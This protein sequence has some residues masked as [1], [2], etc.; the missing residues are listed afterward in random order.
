MK[1]IHIYANNIK[2]WSDYVKNTDCF[3]NAYTNLENLKQSL[4]HYNIRDVLGF[5]LYPTIFTDEIFTFLNFI[6]NSYLSTKIPVILVCYL[7][8]KALTM[9]SNTYP[10]L[11]LYNLIPEDDT[12]SDLDINNI[13]TLLYAANDLIYD[14]KEYKDKHVHLYDKK[15]K[16]TNDAMFVLDLIER[17]TLYE[18][19]E[20]ESNK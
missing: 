20:E 2:V 11:S 7:D 9:L 4:F 5:I 15:Q 1:F 19:N 13:L 17:G 6:D 8:S 12:I 3:V 16:L 14:V 18:F 10:K